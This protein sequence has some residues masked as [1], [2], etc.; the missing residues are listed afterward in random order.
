[1]VAEIT[2]KREKGYEICCPMCGTPESKSTARYP[3][4]QAPGESEAPEELE[5]YDRFVGSKDA[6]GSEYEEFLKK[7]Y[8]CSHEWGETVQEDAWLDLRSRK[9]RKCGIIHCQI[10]DEELVLAEYYEEK[11]EK[12]R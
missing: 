9:C 6:L 4:A 1:M 10:R 3:D 11:P 7:V 2:L 12:E 8:G 5:E